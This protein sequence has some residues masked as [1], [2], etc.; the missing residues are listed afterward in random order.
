MQPL[1]NLEEAYPNSGRSV[2]V[3][4]L[5]QPVGIKGGGLDQDLPLG[6]QSVLTQG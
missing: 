5:V 6:R 4:E 1:P 3:S 2:A